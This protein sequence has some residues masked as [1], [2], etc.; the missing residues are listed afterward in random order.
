MCKFSEGGWLSVCVWVVIVKVIVQILLQF[1][2]L[3]FILF[4]ITIMIR[5]VKRKKAKFDG[6]SSYREARLHGG[7]KHNLRLATFGSCVNVFSVFP[8]LTFSQ[9]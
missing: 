6:P 1:L 7:N 9:A 2:F 5:F 4:I 8:Q 3:I